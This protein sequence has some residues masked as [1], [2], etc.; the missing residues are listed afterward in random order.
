[1]EISEKILMEIISISI[2]Y[3]QTHASS[4]P[5][6]LLSNIFGPNSDVPKHIIEHID[7]ICNN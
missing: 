6:T 2:N 5:T 4:V 1:M 3:Y 7:A